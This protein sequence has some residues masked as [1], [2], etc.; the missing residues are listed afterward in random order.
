MPET[1]AGRSGS[2]GRNHDVPW[3]KRLRAL[4]SHVAEAG[5][6]ERLA[7]VFGG[8]QCEDV[9]WH[10]LALHIRFGMEADQGAAPRHQRATDLGKPCVQRFP[11]VDGVDSAHLVERCGLEGERL[12][13]ADAKL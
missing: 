2:T 9:G 8:P 11:E 3:G 6:P 10:A 13:A 5:L 7:H 12:D 1:R 4:R